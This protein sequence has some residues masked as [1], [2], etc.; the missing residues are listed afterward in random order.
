MKRM[1]VPFLFIATLFLGAC[2][3]Q[4]SQTLAQSDKYEVISAINDFYAPFYGKSTTELG[5]KYRGIISYYHFLPIPGTN[6]PRYDV[7]EIILRVN[8]GVGKATVKEVKGKG[9]AHIWNVSD[10][11]FSKNNPDIKNALSRIAFVFKK[12]GS[13]RPA[14]FYP[15]H[16]KKS[17][18][19]WDADAKSATDLSDGEW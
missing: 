12:N 4:P 3:S 2:S 14:Y 16:P 11:P 9:L 10:L 1:V 6:P 17:S 13:L 15:K 18:E 5:E 7:R 19:G 8:G